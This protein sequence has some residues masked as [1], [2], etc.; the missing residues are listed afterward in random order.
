MRGSR[1]ALLAAVGLGLAMT[2]C[3]RGGGADVTASASA[4]APSSGMSSAQ[5]APVVSGTAGACAV[6]TWK[7]TGFTTTLATAGVT[8]TATGGGGFTLSIG[9]DGATT[10]DFTGMQPVVF[11]TSVAGADVKGSF[12][13]GGKVAGTVRL[14]ATSGDSGAWEPV[15]AADFSALTVT[16]DLLSPVQARVADKLPITQF[17]G[18]QTGGAVDSTPILRSGTYRCTPSTLTLGPPENTPAGASWTLQRA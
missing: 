6:G 3:D 14:P 7:S 5:A 12:T 2:G 9:P 16:V 18:A 4:A 1:L 11:A 10:V 13:Y 15:G 8:A 17:V